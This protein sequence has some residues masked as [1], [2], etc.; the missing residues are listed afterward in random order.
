M[1]SL[2]YVAIFR[3]NP[4]CVLAASVREKTVAALKCC[5]VFMHETPGGVG[6]KFWM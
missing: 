4:P 1:I 2:Q 5:L 6:V 3:L